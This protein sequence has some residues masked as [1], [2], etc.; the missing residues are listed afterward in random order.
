MRVKVRALML[1]LMLL[2]M[3]LRGYAAA[4]KD[5][6]D[7]HHSGSQAA[8]HDAHEHAGEHENGAHGGDK[9]HAG[10]A[11]HCG[12]CSTCSVGASLV[13]DPLPPIASITATSPRIP[14]LAQFSPGVSLD[15]PDRPPLAS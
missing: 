14:F 13:S 4:V 8:H 2:A 12:L 15:H 9:D 5:F 1:V 11:S 7:A 3:P 6:C 10:G